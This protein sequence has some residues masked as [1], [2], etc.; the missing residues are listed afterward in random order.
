MGK[1]LLKNLWRHFERQ[2]RCARDE[3]SPEY[4]MTLLFTV[5]KARRE[6]P[7]FTNG[8]GAVKC[9]PHFLCWLAINS[10]NFLPPQPTLQQTPFLKDWQMLSRTQVDL[11]LSLPLYSAICHKPYRSHGEGQY[12]A[13]TGRNLK[14]SE[15][16]VCPHCSVKQGPGEGCLGARPCSG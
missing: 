3:S 2:K 9:G 8:R 16:K 11:I 14:T 13:S 12:W 7:V 5:W 4:N 10:L 1:I 15:C 6:S